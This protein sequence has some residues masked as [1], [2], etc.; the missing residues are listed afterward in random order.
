MRKYRKPYGAIASGL[1]K[2]LPAKVSANDRR[3]AKL[4][5]VVGRPE[6]KYNEADS[7]G[8]DY[9]GAISGT[10]LNPQKLSEA[11]GRNSRIGDKVLSKRIRFNCIFKMEQNPSAPTCAIRLLV[12]RSKFTNPSTSDMPTWYGSVDED[13]FFVIKDITTQ[14]TAVQAR[15][16]SGSSFETGS[17]MKNF[18]FSLPTGFRKL[19]Y[20]GQSLQSP[21]NNEYIIY[22]LAENGVAQV[23][24]N[25]KHYYIDN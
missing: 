18:K 10:L 6:T 3:I 4:Q 5:K 13:K 16:V 21:L 1:T 20:D 7:G 24:Y 9:V 23:A 11:V 14:V 25:W 19:Q 12:L 2:S 17:T 15:T 22:M 8:F